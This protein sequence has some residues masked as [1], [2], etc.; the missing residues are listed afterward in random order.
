MTTLT[1]YM[2]YFEVMAR[3]EAVRGRIR[4]LRFTEGFFSFMTVFCGAILG[5]TLVQGFL[6]F[7]PAGRL[8]LLL[9]GAGAILWAF[10]R[11]ILSPLRREP[12]FKEVARF[13]EIRLP[14]LGN[15][16]INTLLLTERASEWSPVLVQMAVS[17]A[18][19]GVVGIDLLQA[20][21]TRRAK[22]WAAAAAAA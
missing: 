15:S 1:N 3:I 17:E 5:A 16:L 14:E 6:R 22:R 18:A 4:T 21:N 20:T 10:W 9:V 2:P 11:H 8:A 13:I 19:A 12:N 7:G